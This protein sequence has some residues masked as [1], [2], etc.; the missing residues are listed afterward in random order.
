MKGGD[1]R[2]GM[3]VRDGENCAC[4]L[5]AAKERERGGRGKTYTHVRF[6]HSLTHARIPTDRRKLRSRVHLHGK[7]PFR[8]V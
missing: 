7:L 4:T 2:G 6:S 5:C 1:G 3:N 8:G